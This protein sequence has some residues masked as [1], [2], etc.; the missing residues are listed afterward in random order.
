VTGSGTGT[1]PTVVGPVSGTGNFIKSAGATLRPA[2]ITG[3]S[4][5]DNALTG[6]VG[7]Y[8]SQAKNSTQAVMVNASGTIINICSILLGGG[9][10]DVFGN[11]NFIT[12]GNASLR[13]ATISTAPAVIPDDGF[14][15]ADWDSSGLNPVVLSVGL[16]PRRVSLNVPTTVYLCGTV[17]FASGLASAYGYIAARRVR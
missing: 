2:S 17:S 10:W 7:E 14:N 9:D 8:V 13:Q 5:N 16:P 11:A 12:S 3:T 1:V 6:A 4:T 15:A